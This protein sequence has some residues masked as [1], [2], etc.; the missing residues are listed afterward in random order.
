[1]NEWNDPYNPFNS[2]KILIWNEHLKA[3]AKDEFPIPITSDTDPTNHCNY[4][5]S[6][7]N[8]QKYRAKGKFMLSEEQLIEMANIHGD[9]GIV[10]TCIAGGGEPCLNPHLDKF[11][12]QLSFNNVDSGVITNGSVMTESQMEAITDCCR[13]TGFSMDAGNAD[14]F[15]EIK[16]IK[17]KNIFNNVIH[18]LEKLCSMRIK[19]NSRIDIA[20]KFLMFPSNVHTIFEAAK[21]AKNCGVQHF[22]LRPGC[23]DNLQSDLNLKKVVFDNVID[24]AKNQIELSKE[25]ECETFKVFGVQ[26]K[27]GEKWQRKVNFKKCRAV[28]IMPTFGADGYVHLCFD[29]RDKDGWILCKHTDVIKMWGSEKHRQIVNSIDPNKCPRCTYG[30]YNEII[31]RVFIED[32]MCR[33]FP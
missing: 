13:Y 11:I 6:H 27:F 30:V 8:A 7:C 4:N 25:L 28:S 16:N 1:M 10:S 2:M 5:C 32:S 9:W 12:R 21:L 22:H 17:D 23:T 29:C 20:F 19:K 14:V 18:N 33:D 15:I 24:T 31:E 26:H 3:Y